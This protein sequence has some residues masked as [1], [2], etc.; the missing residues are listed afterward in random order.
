MTKIKH[1]DILELSIPERLKLVQEIW[2]SIREFPEEIPLTQEQKDELDRRLEEHRAD[3]DSAIPWT[4]VR[5]KLKGY[6]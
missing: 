1:S 6:I 2:E 3:P 4:V 5:E